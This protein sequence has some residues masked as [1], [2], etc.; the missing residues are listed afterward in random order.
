MGM[1]K[2]LSEK[3]MVARSRSQARLGL[4]R[5]ALRQ[6]DGVPGSVILLFLA[7]IEAGEPLTVTDLEMTRF[8]MTLDDAVDLV[9]FARAW[10]SGR[11]LCAEGARRRSRLCRG[12]QAVDG[13]PDHPVKV[14]GTRKARSC[15]RRC[16]ARNGPPRSGQLLP[17]PVDL[18][19]PELQP[20]FTEGMCVG[21]LEDY[22][23]HNTTRLDVDGMIELP[24][25][26]EVRKM[27][28]QGAGAGAGSREEGGRAE[29]GEAR[30]KREGWG[31]DEVGVRRSE[32]GD[33]GKG[34][35][36]VRR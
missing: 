22:H 11:S 7:Q 26:R 16:Y 36:S 28:R 24:L 1:S 14:I 8:M 13:A 23:S 2:A 4:L 9:L 31:G 21:R 33:G 27:G 18:S 35:A 32:M 5:H 25:A 12:A 20:Y 3:I 19:R 6:R 17:V 34:G 10:A 30:G 15:T 29:K